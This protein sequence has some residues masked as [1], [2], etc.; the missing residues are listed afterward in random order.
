MDALANGIRLTD[1]SNNGY[2]NK[3]LI[4]S[5]KQQIANQKKQILELTQD[6]DLY[7]AEVSYW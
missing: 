5:L 7:R 6:R 4:N 3:E 2:N 1:I